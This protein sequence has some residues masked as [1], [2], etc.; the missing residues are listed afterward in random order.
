M[1]TPKKFFH[2]HVVLLLLSTN[3][4]IVA[5]CIVSILYRLT[6]SQGG[7]YIVQFRPTLGISAYQSGSVIELI[8]FAAFAVLAFVIQLILSIRV[9]HIRRQLALAILGMGIV[10]LM[11]AA[12]ISNS[13]LALR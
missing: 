13:L 6:A 3:A 7:G 11:L 4:F 8:G 9:Y 12:I 2:D 10:V 1:A 5:A